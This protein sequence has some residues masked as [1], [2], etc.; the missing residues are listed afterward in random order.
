MVRCAVSVFT[1]MC[2]CSVGVF[3]LEESIADI[4]S[5]LD[6]SSYH[7]QGAHLFGGGDQ[8][9]PAERQQQRLGLGP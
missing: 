8:G 4:L 5:L 6:C 2:A 1:Y 7:C 3:I 9:D